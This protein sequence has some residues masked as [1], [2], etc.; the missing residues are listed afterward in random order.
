MPGPL[1]EPLAG[2]AAA[3]T[4]TALPGKQH[5]AV[6]WPGGGAMLAA[7]TWPPTSCGS[8]TANLSLVRKLHLGFLWLPGG[9]PALSS[10]TPCLPATRPSCSLLLGLTCS[11]PCLGGSCALSLVAYPAQRP[12]AVTTS[13]GHPPAPPVPLCS[14]VR[15]LWRES[16]LRRR[17]AGRIFVRVY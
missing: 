14:L 1:P 9:G 3:A 8:G 17:R 15:G 2:Q 13:S 6:G 10:T 7:P 16:A 11:F 12:P 5:R 4:H